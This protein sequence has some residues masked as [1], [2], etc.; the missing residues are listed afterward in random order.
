MASRRLVTTILAGTAF[1][2]AASALLLQACGGGG[3]TSSGGADAT[4]DGTVIDSP[5]DSP[6]DASGDRGDAGM[7]DAGTGDAVSD[8]MNFTDIGDV[9]IDV[10]PLSAFPHAID[11]A[12]CERVREC[13]AVPVNQWDPTCADQIDSVG[14]FFNQIQY[15]AA[16][17]SGLIA[18]DA[19]A[20]FSCL[21]DFLAV[22]CNTVNSMGLN[23]LTRDCFG[24]MQ[25]T[26]GIDAGPCINTLE[27]AAG[28]CAL[29][30][31]GGPGI[32]KAL[33]AVG[34]PCK[35]TAGSTDCTYLGNGV[36]AFHCAL[37]DSGAATCQPDLPNNSACNFSVECA[38]QECDNHL[39]T[40]TLIFVNNPA[41]G[42]CDS[43]TVVDGGTD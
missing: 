28:F 14:G 16:L 13:C 24:A 3:G 15:S 12:Y 2:S 21:H 22:N 19:S 34:Q 1:A 35:D 42:V 11:V 37:G 29:A 17:D 25:G 38:S 9:A 32:C 8:V 39:C 31:D 4:A 10:P 20:A 18:Y 7:G 41:T 30:L 40:S 43:F 27:C 23:Q 33:A 26:L 5:A 6:A 36:P